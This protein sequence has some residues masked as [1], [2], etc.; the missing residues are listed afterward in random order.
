MSREFINQKSEALRAIIKSLN[1]G[2]VVHLSG[3]AREVYDDL[4]AGGGVHT[5]ILEDNLEYFYIDRQ[6]EL[7]ITKSLQ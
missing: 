1:E 6:T 3:Y 5:M 4:V 7:K 2:K